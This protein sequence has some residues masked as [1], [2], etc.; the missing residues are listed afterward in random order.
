VVGVFHSAAQAGRQA[1]RQAV[2]GYL[3]AAN[4][5]KS[6]IKKPINQSRKKRKE[7][8]NTKRQI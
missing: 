4:P 6:K 8:K 7:R 3:S 1:G 2:G 5:V